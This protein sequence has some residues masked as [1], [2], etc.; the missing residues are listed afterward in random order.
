MNLDIEFKNKKFSI[1]NANQIGLNFKNLIVD[2]LNYRI[3]NNILIWST[4]ESD[5][6][7]GNENYDFRE[8]N[9]FCES[10]NIIVYIIFGA[11]NQEHYR[12]INCF[13]NI[14]L[15]FWPTYLLNYTYNK[16][17]NYYGTDITNLKKNQSFENL[18]VCYNN[19]PHLHRCKLIDKL[20]QRDLFNHGEISWNI[21]NDINYDFKSWKEKILKIDNFNSES[22]IGSTHLIDNTSLVSLIT[23]STDNLA[24]I[25]EK[26]YKSI[27]I[28]QPFICIGGKLQ[29]VILKNLGFVLYDELFDYSFD[30]LNDIDK[31]IDGLIE[32]LIRIKDCDYSNLYKSVECKI[33]HNKNVAVSIV[34][35]KLYIPEIITKNNIPFES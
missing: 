31:R 18:F 9:E 15:D 19:K 35:D 26:T 27:L 16:L 21:L 23:E 29:N 24:F 2:V 5:L 14:K 11:F 10:H 30:Y 1:Y 4:M 17:H 7:G 33:K 6:P 12:D 22:V 8:F 34:R 32:N 3:H 28:E 20:S 25:T 13:K